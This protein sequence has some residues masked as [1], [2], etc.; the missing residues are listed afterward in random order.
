MADDSVQRRKNFIVGQVGEEALQILR[1]SGLDIDG[2]LTRIVEGQGRQREELEA[3]AEFG[4]I[5][6]VMSSELV[7]RSGKLTDV[8]GREFSRRL[9]L[10]GLDGNKIG[11]LYEQEKLILSSNIGKFQPDREQPWARRYFFIDGTKIDELPKQGQLALSE[12][13]LITDDASSAYARDHHAL[14]ADT[15][16]AVCSAAVQAASWG[17]AQYG[18][19]LRNRVKAMGWSPQ[20][21]GAFTRNECMLTERLKWGYHKNPAWTE[22]TANPAQYKR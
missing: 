18:F 19:A 14:S 8:Y 4:D 13:V 15:W 22:E 12:L 11:S 16:H 5:N 20:Q 17:G 2:A 3:Q 9:S 10:M 7:Y 1:D 6:D 21:E